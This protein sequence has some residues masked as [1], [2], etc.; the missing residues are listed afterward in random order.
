M[1]WYDDYDHLGY[2]LEGQK[3]CKPKRGDEL[4]KFLSK[5]D[6]PDFGVTVRDPLTGKDVVLSES[7][8]DTIRR[9]MGN[10]G[11]GK[12]FEE[13]WSEWFSSEVLETPVRDL[14]E[15]KRSFVPSL[16]EKRKVSRMVRAIKMGWMKVS[17]SDPKAKPDE[18]PDK[19]AFYML[20]KA[21]DGEEEEMRRIRDLIPAPKMK[22]PGHA[23]S[24]NPPPEYLFTE[25]ERE[26]WESLAEE[27]YKRRLDFVPAKFDSLRKVPGYSR[28]IAERF[29]RCL[30]LYLA[31]RARK[32][33]LTIQPEDLVPP[34]PKPQDLQP[35]PQVCA[36]TYKGHRNLVR[37]L[38]VEPP[39]GGENGR[40]SQF[41]ASGSDDGTVRVWE[42]QT[43]YCHRTFKFG[44]KSVVHSVAWCPNP[45]LSLLAVAVDD[46]VVLLNAG[47][48]DKLV[49]RQ[50]SELL[51]SGT[52]SVADSAAAGDEYVPPERVRTAVTWMSAEEARKLSSR[53]EDPAA[54][55]EGSSQ[56]E[57]RREP[58]GGVSSLPKET[59]VVLKVFR[60]VRQ[61]SWHAK[62]D[63]F[64][65][66]CPDGANRSVLIH[67]LSRRRS[68]IPFSK[69][70]GLVQRVL[71][72]PVRPY[73][74]VATQRHVRIYDLGKQQLC[75]KL[76]TGAKWISSIAVHPTGDHVLVATFDKRLQWFDLD[77]S[78]AAPYQV[79]RYHAAAVRDVAFHR[80]YPL[81]ASCSDDTSV[82]VSHGM[83]YND[84]LQ[85]PLIV[86]VK[87]L[88]GHT[89]YDDFGVM[90]VVW[91]PSQPWLLSSGADGH[92]KLWT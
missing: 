39:G 16:D 77:L 49:V 68:Q 26:R 25:K 58:S 33:R 3:I 79:L 52:A 87:H 73:L 80:R 9:L 10:K 29:E 54:A 88:R 83:V 86:P 5:M 91:H 35:F 64:A 65:T 60:T 55:A 36:L 4:D 47:V 53:E 13:E 69:A 48:G 45:A 90:C 20:W 84:L 22:L 32:M 31:P 8:V 44:A 40:A 71:F 17:S 92:I 63:Y 1:N 7:D 18:E 76:M 15:H 38:T 41:F 24:Y 46:L 74:L 23:E 19:K 59:L 21:D 34:L 28:F 30:D 14:P 70:K 61:V 62:G 56:G 89:K 72:H 67:Q 66:V 78:A 37:S 11:D 81:F 43:G 85:N 2:N 57:S 51:L 42:L 12:G 27:P 75:K 6:D 50:T 82:I